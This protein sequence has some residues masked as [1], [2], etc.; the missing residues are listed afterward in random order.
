MVVGLGLELMVTSW[1]SLVKVWEVVVRDLT[2]AQLGVRC[3]SSHGPR[4]SRPT[5]VKWS[6]G[7]RVWS[8]TT[9]GVRVFGLTGLVIWVLLGIEKVIHEEFCAGT[10]DEAPCGPIDATA[11]CLRRDIEGNVGVGSGTKGKGEHLV[12]EV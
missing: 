2:V 10:R 9:P 1:L 3:R 6:P 8:L 4:S 11:R 7:V 12:V 5:R